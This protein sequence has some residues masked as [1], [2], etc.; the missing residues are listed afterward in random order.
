MPREL[1]VILR[2]W[3][4]RIPWTWDQIAAGAQ[5]AAAR[6]GVHAIF[7]AD[8]LA[9]NWGWSHERKGGH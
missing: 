9:A 6:Q 1:E 7:A 2:R 3:I 5:A 4:A 8:L